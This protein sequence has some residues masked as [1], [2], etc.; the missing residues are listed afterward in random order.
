MLQMMAQPMPKS[1]LRKNSTLGELLAAAALVASTGSTM[2][3]DAHPPFLRRGVAATAW[4]Y[5]N[6]DHT[7]YFQN[8]GFY[9]GDFAANPPS[10]GIGAAGMF[11]FRP[12][13]GSHYAPIYCTRRYRSHNPAPS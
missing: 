8:N 12:A 1:T 9:P 10:A 2:A 3:Q 6:R 11:G 5:D 7:R 13:G 4:D